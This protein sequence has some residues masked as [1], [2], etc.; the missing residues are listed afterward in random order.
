MGIHPTEW[1]DSKR[2]GFEWDLKGTTV[3]THDWCVLISI[4]LANTY[5]KPPPRLADR[6][7]IPSLLALPEKASL[8]IQN[9]VPPLSD[10]PIL[11]I[12]F[13]SA[14]GGALALPPFCALGFGWPSWGLGV[15]GV[16]ARLERWLFGRLTTGGARNVDSEKALWSIASDRS[17]TQL[18][19][20]E[21]AQ[22]GAQTLVDEKV[23][24]LFS[25]LEESKLPVRGLVFMDYF[26]EPN[27]Q[28]VR[29][30]VE[31]NF[32]PRN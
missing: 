2:E 17:D 3:R 22:A 32:I 4:S 7:N 10:P 24:S 12:T 13:L 19:K 29:L 8:C 16:N 28:L 31:N 21:K 27:G 18:L 23:E 20:D 1:P 6:Y 30:L 14:S 15:E 11:A 9:L 25:A 26:A 5:L